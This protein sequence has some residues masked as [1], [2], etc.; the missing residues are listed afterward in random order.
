MSDLDLN[1]CACTRDG[2]AEGRKM[3][4]TLIKF[5]VLLLLNVILQTNTILFHYEDRCKARQTK[6]QFVVQLSWPQWG[7]RR[8]G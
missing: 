1:N 4:P 5:I 2:G 8:R 7:W 6:E 3:N